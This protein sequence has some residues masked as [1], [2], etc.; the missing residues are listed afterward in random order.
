[1]VTANHATDGET[2]ACCGGRSPTGH[3]HH[4]HA[5]AK[6]GMLDPV[7][8]MAVNPET[9][10]HRFEYNGE[11]FHFCSAGC[12]SRFAADPE[13]QDLHLPDAS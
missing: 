8:G 1:M 5:H 7:C 11:T 3:E 2:K 12:R 6:A 13:R 10:K 4:H 9:S